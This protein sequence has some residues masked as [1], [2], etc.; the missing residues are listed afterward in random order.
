MYRALALAILFAS[1][2]ALANDTGTIQDAI[3]AAAV[4]ETV[5]L[6]PGSYSVSGAGITIDKSLTFAMSKGTTL[7]CS[8][9]P[10]CITISD[11]SGV[12]IEGGIIA[13]TESSSNI[14]AIYPHGTVSDLTVEGVTVVGTGRAADGTHGHQRGFWN[15]SGQTLS[16]I[17]ILHSAFRDVTLGISLNAESSGSVT[18]AVV[19]GNDI[20]DVY[21]GSPGQGYGIHHANGSGNASL[22]RITNNTIRG[23]QRHS[24]YQAKGSDVV[25][26]ENS[27]ASHRA[28]LAPGDSRGVAR[29]AINVARSRNVVVMGNTIANSYDGAIGVWGTEDANWPD[30]DIT[31][32]GNVVSN[33]R[34]FPA[35]TIGTANPPAETEPT[36]IIVSGNVFA[37]DMN[38]AD[39][40]TQAAFIYGGKQVSII[41][42]HVRFAGLSGIGYGFFLHGSGETSGTAN[43]TDDIR[44]LG[45]QLVGD[46][47]G[48]LRFFGLSTAMCAAASRLEFVSN[49]GSGYAATFFRAAAQA[50]TNIR[51]VD[52][53]ADGLNAWMPV[54]S[55]NSAA[56]AGGVR[57]GQPYRTSSGQVMVRY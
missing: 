40:Y 11:A 43:Y 48:T 7:V 32:T 10:A 47:G 54:Y 41:G 19:D 29:F 24:I 57:L 26:A 39:A 44:F 6:S 25:I 8:A 53:A 20:S 18:G 14:T 3:R 49:G 9:S 36:S 22:V 5:T 30:S 34:S 27:I 2:S 33:W 56:A 17:R 45:N 52:Q 28:T 23:T 4:G 31:I 50:N 51:T 42:N 21:G 15:Q 16:D 46:G 55:D 1:G 38:L 12:R 13:L 37:Q 35:L